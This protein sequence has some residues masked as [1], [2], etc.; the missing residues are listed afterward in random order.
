M[1]PEAENGSLS[2]FSARNAA[3]ARSAPSIRKNAKQP[4][5]TRLSQVPA[6]RRSSGTVNAVIAI[7]PTTTTP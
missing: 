4:H 1:K 7:R 5:S 3:R 6:D 2:R